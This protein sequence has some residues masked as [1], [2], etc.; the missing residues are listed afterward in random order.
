MRKLHLILPLLCLLF[1]RC[2]TSEQLHYDKDPRDT[3]LR[4]SNVHEVKKLL[5]LDFD[6]V[7]EAADEEDQGGISI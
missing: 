3:I 2:N 5:H 7:V 6:F 4:N 1:K